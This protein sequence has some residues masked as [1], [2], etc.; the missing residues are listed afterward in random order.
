MHVC[1]Y[2]YNKEYHLL[3]GITWI[4]HI[5]SHILLTIAEEVDIIM[6]SSQVGNPKLREETQVLK[7]TDSKVLTIVPHKKI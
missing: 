5:S 3:F 1:R 2:F 7:V 6:S 4:S